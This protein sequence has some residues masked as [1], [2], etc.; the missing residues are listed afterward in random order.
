MWRD[1]PKLRRLLFD[2]VPMKGDT[3]A[4]QKDAA[5]KGGQSARPPRAPAAS[6]ASAASGAS[7]S[8]SSA[9]KFNSTSV[10]VPALPFPISPDKLRMIRSICQESKTLRRFLNMGAIPGTNTENAIPGDDVTYAKSQDD[11]DYIDLEK[12]P[13]QFLSGAHVCSHAGYSKI[14]TRREFVGDPKWKHY[15]RFSLAMDPPYH[16]GRI[17]EQKSGGGYTDCT[18][19]PRGCKVKTYWDKAGGAFYAQGKHGQTM[20]EK[21]RGSRTATVMA[22]LQAYFPLGSFELSLGWETAGDVQKE[23]A[24]KILAGDALPDLK[25]VENFRDGRT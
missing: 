15:Q 2:F 21:K 24:T 1:G 8:A 3:S 18:S 4:K 10:E 25:A 6:A 19:C 14:D 11:F 12:L 13:S 5:A 9:F 17:R 23:L 20:A 7:S 16:V 22:A